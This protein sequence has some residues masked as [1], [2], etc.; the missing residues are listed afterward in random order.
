M[1]DEQHRPIDQSEPDERAERA[2]RLAGFMV[3]RRP[4]GT[5]PEATQQGDA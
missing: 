4:R 5:T 3:A 2:D 1:R